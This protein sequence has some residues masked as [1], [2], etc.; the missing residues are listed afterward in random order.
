MK[1]KKLEY[2]SYDAAKIRCMMGVRYW[3]DSKVNDVEDTD[4]DLIPLRKKDIWDIT[5][6]LTSGVIENWPVGITASIH[7]KVCDDGEYQLL[8]N[9]NELV[10]KA[11][12]YVPNF[13]CPNDSGYGDYI[14]MDVDGDGHI[15]GWFLEENDLSVYFNGNE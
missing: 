6:N 10:V 14:I 12:G 9:D 8:G 2:V 13:L 7:Y 11:S 5:I 4:G 3:E 15:D 1:F